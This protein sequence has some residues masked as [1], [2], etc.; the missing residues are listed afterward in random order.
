MCIS[1][2]NFAHINVFFN[3]NCRLKKKLTLLHCFPRGSSG[4]ESACNGGGAD[5]GSIPG[6]GRFPGE[7]NSYP[8][9]YSGLENTMDYTVAKSQDTDFHFLLYWMYICVFE[10]YQCCCQLRCLC[11]TLLTAVGQ[12][13]LYCV[14]DCFRA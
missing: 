6:L 5:L 7:G 11:N 9:Q 12:F 13:P 8:L 4:K 10:F 14:V 3:V 1:E 2:S